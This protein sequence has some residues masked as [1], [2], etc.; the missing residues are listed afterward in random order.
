MTTVEDTAQLT[1]RRALD[2]T[3]PGGTYTFSGTQ[4]SLQEIADELEDVTGRTFARHSHGPL[5]ELE[6]AIGNEQDPY[7]AM[8]L[9]HQLALATTPPFE[10]THHD[11]YPD[12]T[13]TGLREQLQSAYG[14]RV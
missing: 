6:T 7:A 2:D 12:L 8:G 1:A 4:T 10:T 13:L 14:A 9:W 11:R 3:A 5:S